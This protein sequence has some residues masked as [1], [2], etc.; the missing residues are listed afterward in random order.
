MRKNDFEKS[1]YSVILFICTIT[2]IAFPM[3]K[4]FFN[5]ESYLSL[6]GLRFIKQLENIPLFTTE[7]SLSPELMFT[8]AEPIKKIKNLKDFPQDK[9]F[10]LFVVDTIPKQFQKRFNTTFIEQFDENSI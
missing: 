6:D 5:N 9:S 4:M 7:S 2:L 10:G 3:A 8:L 1:F